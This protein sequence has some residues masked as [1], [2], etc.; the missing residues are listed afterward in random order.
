MWNRP[1]FSTELRTGAR[2]QLCHYWTSFRS[3]RSE[4]FASEEMERET[5]DQLQTEVPCNFGCDGSG[6]CPERRIGLA[7]SGTDAIRTRTGGGNGPG[8]YYGGG[9][10]P[11]YYS[12]WVGPAFLLWWR[13][14]SRTFPLKSYETARDPSCIQKVAN[15][16][17]KMAY[18]PVNDILSCP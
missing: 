10:R 2:V 9:P 17:A 3:S 1:I 6:F 16:M 8:P 12:G 18:L 5:R 13:L 7:S 15:E 11:A 14:A 4:R